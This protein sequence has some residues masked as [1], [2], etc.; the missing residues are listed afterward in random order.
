MC[1]MKHDTLEAAFWSWLFYIL[2]IN[3]NQTSSIWLDAVDEVDE[4]DGECYWITG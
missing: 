2:D 4:S 1:V 3:G